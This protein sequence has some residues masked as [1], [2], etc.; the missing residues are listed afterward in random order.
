MIEN[1][2][3]KKEVFNGWK[4]PFIVVMIEL[5][6]IEKYNMHFSP[7]KKKKGLKTRSPQFL[8]FGY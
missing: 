7:M 1:R 4:N 5:Q 6:F 8:K 3:T 2:M